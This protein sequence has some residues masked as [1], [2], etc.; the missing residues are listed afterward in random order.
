M[1][2]RSGTGRY[3]A[4]VLAVAGFGCAVPVL[5]VGYCW[6]VLAFMVWNWHPCTG[7][8]ITLA[9]LTEAAW[10][11]ALIPL[12]G[13]AAAALVRLATGSWPAAAFA[14]AAPAI[15]MS[16]IVA[17]ILDGCARVESPVWLETIGMGLIL[18][19]IVTALAVWVVGLARLTAR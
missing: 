10:Q 1:P 16:P 7:F 14:L 8:S 6:G 18:A 12:A 17:D 4:R 5:W 19:V 13:L 3:V 2:D 9:E 11:L 15:V